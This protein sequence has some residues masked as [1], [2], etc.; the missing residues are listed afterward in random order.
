MVWDSLSHIFGSPVFFSKKF[1]FS[2]YFSN[3]E[4]NI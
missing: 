4:L 3:I 2:K 1:T